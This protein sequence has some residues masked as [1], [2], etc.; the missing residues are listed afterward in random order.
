MKVGSTGTCREGSS[1]TSEENT[2]NRSVYEHRF[3]AYK[4]NQRDPFD[5]KCTHLKDY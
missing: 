2:A 5:F 1:N 3:N 4:I